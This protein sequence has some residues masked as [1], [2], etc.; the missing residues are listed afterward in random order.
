MVEFMTHTIIFPRFGWT[1]KIDPTPFSVYGWEIH[2]YG[3]IIACGFVLALLYGCKRSKAFGIKSDDVIDL[4]LWAA[5]L[6]IIGARLYYCLFNFEYYIEN[7]GN[8][9]RIWDGGLAFYGSMIAAVLTV[10]IFTK[11]KKINVYSMLDI[12][13][14]G[15]LIGQIIG[16]WG[17]FVNAEA[18]GRDIAA[19][20]SGQYPFYAMIVSTHPESAV[21]PVFLY[22]SL[23]N[24]LLFIGLHFY[25]KHRRFN[26]EI[27]LWYAA[28]YGII[29]TLT[30]SIRGND[31][32]LLW[33]TYDMNMPWNRVSF[34]LAILIFAAA[35]IVLIVLYIRRANTLKKS[36]VGKGSAQHAEIK[37][38]QESAGE[39]VAD[40]ADAE[41]NNEQP[42]QPAKQETLPD[43]VSG[44]ENPPK[45]DGAE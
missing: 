28:G 6:G 25:S 5:P 16:R 14:L 7:P 1:F 4:L 26:G 37:P 36:A 30:E 39:K 42:T 35:L 17:N 44:E 11:I 24:L 20:A 45:Q 40:T 19:N 23:L 10:L 29:R 34:L 8:I 18:Y 32:L 43:E 33:G 27:F 15:L 38:Y 9:I 2:W 21:H 41:Q 13:A 3:I 31:S 12:G 22:E